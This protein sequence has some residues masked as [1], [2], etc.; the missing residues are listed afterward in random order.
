[1]EG[2]LPAGD[3][4]TQPGNLGSTGLCSEIALVSWSGSALT[5]W[6]SGQAANLLKVSGSSPGLSGVIVSPLLLLCASPSLICEL[7]A[8]R[9]W[10]YDV[11]DYMQ[12]IVGA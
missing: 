3:L 9:H 8:G 7:L 6:L 12:H 4:A 11:C 10:D 2:T 1:M 5:G